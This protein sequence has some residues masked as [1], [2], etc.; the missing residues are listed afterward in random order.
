MCC[1]GGAI[2]KQATKGNGVIFDVAHL[3]DVLD[4]SELS[5]DMGKTSKQLLE[6]D[7]RDDQKTSRC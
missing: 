2:A 6:H 1:R 3:Y 7:Q 5:D 4:V